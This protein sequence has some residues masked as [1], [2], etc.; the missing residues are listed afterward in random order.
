MADLVNQNGIQVW[1]MCDSWIVGSCSHDVVVQGQRKEMLGPEIVALLV[2]NKI[3]LPDHF[4]E[5]RVGGC[6]DL[7]FEAVRGNNLSL[8]NH[9]IQ[10]LGPGEFS[11][12]LLNGIFRRGSLDM[13]QQ[14]VAKTGVP[15]S[16]RRMV[17]LCNRPYDRE[18]IDYLWEIGFQF[19]VMVPRSEKFHTHALVVAKRNLP[20]FKYLV[21]E[22]QV[23]PE[24]RIAKFK[25]HFEWRHFWAQM[26]MQVQRGYQTSN[27]WLNFL[28]QLPTHLRRRTV[29]FI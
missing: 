29:L 14:L 12:S 10:L 24:N 25:Y 16:S 20:L 15:E 6:Q 13:I 27:K 18:I 11:T 5:S 26:I 4:E 22:K 9:V 1:N 2:R 3:P 7:M 23:Y 28:V 21:L 17:H 19:N 8:F